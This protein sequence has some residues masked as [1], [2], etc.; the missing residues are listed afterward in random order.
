MP[1]ALTAFPNWV[2]NN[3]MNELQESLQYF[4]KTLMD[5]K[6]SSRALD[7]SCA[8]LEPA[9]GPDGISLPPCKSF[10]EGT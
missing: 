10:C 6:C 8:I 7:Y 3:N 1:W 9:C 4:Q 2:N 5:S